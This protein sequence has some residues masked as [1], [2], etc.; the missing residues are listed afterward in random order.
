MACLVGM[1]LFSLGK[2][3]PSLSFPVSWTKAGAH[4][5]PYLFLF[6]G[7]VGDAGPD[8]G[9]SPPMR[10]LCVY[11]GCAMYRASAAVGVGLGFFF[12]SAFV[13]WFQLVIFV[14][15]FKADLSVN[16][17]FLNS[18]KIKGL[19]LYAGIQNTAHNVWL[20]VV[21]QKSLNVQQLDGHIFIPWEFDSGS[22]P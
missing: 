7:Q 17:F 3:G 12:V 8:R 9:P 18:W 1:A 4:S 10:S 11:L 21:P 16:L 2:A 5:W 14:L 6:S 15:I 19:I 13:F 20:V 22:K